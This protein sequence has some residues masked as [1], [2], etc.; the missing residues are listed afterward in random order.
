MLFTFIVARLS[1]C[2]SRIKQEGEVT[3]ASI[4]P[5][6]THYIIFGLKQNILS[7]FMLGGASLVLNLIYPMNV[8]AGSVPST[9]LPYA[10]YRQRMLDNGWKPDFAGCNS[11]PYP[12]FCAGNAI[13]TGAWRH[14]VDGRKVFINNWPCKHGW[15]VAPYIEWDTE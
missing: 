2:L 15:C 4:R 7:P 11:G 9:E 13:G 12:E 1:A 10:I 3:R 14:H 6:T 8:N 5:K